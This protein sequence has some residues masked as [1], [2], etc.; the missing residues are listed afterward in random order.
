MRMGEAHITRLFGGA[1]GNGQKEAVVFVLDR[2]KQP[3]DPCHEARARELLR[4]GRAAVFRR[5]PFTIIVKDREDGRVSSHRLKFD[6]GSKTN[7]IAIVQ[8]RTD[9]VVFAAELS[10]EW[11][12]RASSNADAD[13][14]NRRV[15]LHATDNS[16]GASP[17]PEE[18]GTRAVGMSHQYGRSAI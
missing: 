16:T 2:T 12:R 3:L 18:G 8:E 4:N 5:Y 13:P 7:G 6:P 9:R 11:D 17:P 14:A 15:C 10:A 1:P